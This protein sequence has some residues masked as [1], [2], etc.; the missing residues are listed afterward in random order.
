MAQDL[1]ATQKVAAKAVFTDKKGNVAPVDGP[2]EWVTSNSEL[3]ALDPNGAIC[4][5]K[6]VG[7]IGT[8]SV[9]AIADADLGEGVKPV[10][11]D[12]EINVVAGEASVG[13]ITFSPPEEQE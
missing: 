13:Q 1:K 4:T 10:R 7:P 5:V 3:L 11:L 12:A 2:I 6:A 8:A 9:S